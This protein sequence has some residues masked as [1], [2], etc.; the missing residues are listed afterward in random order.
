MSCGLSDRRVNQARE[1]A[2]TEQRAA[3]Q[4]D[5]A[6]QSTLQAVRQHAGV[7]KKKKKKEKRMAPRPIFSLPLLTSLCG[8]ANRSIMAAGLIACVLHSSPEVQSAQ[9]WMLFSVL[10][11]LEVEGG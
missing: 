5:A 3:K 2:K 4:S 8:L 1:V 9:A 11:W 10:M 6:R 7:K